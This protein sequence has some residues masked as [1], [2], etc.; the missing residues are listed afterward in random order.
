ME[1][2]SNWEDF[3]AYSLKGMSG[4]FKDLCQTPRPLNLDPAQKLSWQAVLL[5]QLMQL[6]QDNADIHH[7]EKLLKQ[8]ETISDR[9]LGHLNSATFGL[10]G[11]IAS[12]RQ[13]VTMLGYNPLFRWLALLLATTCKPGFCP[14]LLQSAIIRARFIELLGQGVLPK[15]KA[16]NLFIVGIFSLLDQLLEISVDEIFSHVTL[17]EDIVQVLRSQDGVYAPYLAL[18]VACEREDANAAAIANAMGM[19]TTRINQAHLAAIAWA[20]A[21]KL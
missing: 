7:L 19:N 14:A 10:G 20:Q 13:A 3:N 9:L 4:F 17:S 18:A 8:D 6:V 15:G 11:H 21:I 5:L 12:V 2:F 16:D 1:R